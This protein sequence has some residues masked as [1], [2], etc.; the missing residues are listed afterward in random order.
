LKHTSY[1]SVSEYLKCPYR[2]YLSRVEKVDQVQHLA[3]PAGTAFHTMTED[4]DNGEDVR[5][6]QAYLDEAMELD[7]PYVSSRGEDYEW[8][9][10]NGQRMFEKYREWRDATAWEVEAVE[11]QF[12]V[13]PDGLAVPFVGYIDRRFRSRTTGTRIICDIKSGYR[14]PS[15]T[16]QLES[17]G[18]A[19]F[20]RHAEQSDPGGTGEVGSD[21]LALNYYD[22]RRGD[23]TGL[24]WSERVSAVQGLVD[25]VRPVERRILAEDFTPNPGPACR[26][27]PVKQY[28]KF[29]KGK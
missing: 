17:Y 1:S 14:L 9:A 23:S 21:R 19:V 18:A 10:V 7:V 12:S 25:Y 20:H 15:D 27:C 29:R 8:W 26:Y 4:H 24:V 3:G 11:E 16:K 6:Y 5:P 22:A 2:W 13:Q 28:C